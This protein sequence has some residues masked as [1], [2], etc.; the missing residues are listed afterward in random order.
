MVLEEAKIRLLAAKETAEGLLTQI[1]VLYVEEIQSE[2]KVLKDALSELH[3]TAKIDLVK[4]VNKIDKSS[5]GHDLFKVL[6]AFENALPSLDASVEDVINC[7]AH[8]TQQLG[9]NS[10]AGRIY[11]A[12]E[13]FCGVDAQRPKDSVGF[14]LAQ[15]ELSLYAPFLISSILAYDSGHITE[16]IKVTENLLVNRNDIVRR[17]AYFILGRLD[18]NEN[19]ASTIWG[20]LVDSA[21]T[22]RENNCCASILRSIVN[23]G[24][25]F[26]SY[27]SRIEE[28][29]TTFFKRAAPEVLY[30]TSNIA[31]FQR[32]DL[33]ERIL[34]LLVKQL[35]GV[36]PEGNNTINNIDHLLVTLIDKDASSLALELLESVL[37]QGVKLSQLSYFSSELLTKYRE[38]LNHIVTKWFLSGD[39]SLCL[40]VLDLL[41]NVIDENFELE[42]K[43]D[44]VDNDVKRVFVSR[45]AVGWL[46]TKP[47]AAAS[48]V[49]SIYQTTST[50]AREDLEQVLFD[51]LLLSFPGE[52]KQFF[53]AC[54]VKGFLTAPCERLLQKLQIYHSDIEKVSRLKELMAPS[55]NITAYW[56]EFNKGM[57]KTYEERPDSLFIDLIATKK[58]LLYG[59]SSI[60]YIH[61]GDG[62]KT[63]QEMQMQ[64]ISHSTEMPRLDVLDPETLDHS[65]RIYRCERME[66][67]TNT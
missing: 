25:K 61:H 32:V 19:Q 34:E 62:G 67:E 44:L 49:L 16:A 60:F 14:I 23:F 38:L 15:S 59:N 37:G 40:G 13:R 36:S 5:S 4:I 22:E 53:H 46:F 57:Q 51:P 48:F 8:L 58:F 11:G 66:N 7:L 54:I 6:H 33:P 18:V 10:Q 20:I 17:Q 30:E 26:P 2:E 35:A 56:K 55:E 41:N 45:K 12:F 47:R 24:D 52:L 29:L 9:G 65:L 39:I 31:A 21:S 50:A 63:R 28:L 27:W 3:N 1:N 64:S 43:I 42:A